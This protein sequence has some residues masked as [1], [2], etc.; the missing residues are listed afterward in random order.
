MDKDIKDTH[1]TVVILGDGRSFDY[2]EN[3]KILHIPKGIATTPYVWK[4]AKE[5][6]PLNY[7]FNNHILSLITAL[8]EPPHSEDNKE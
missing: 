1:N 8:L 7:H 2:V 5:A 3:C 6:T 4:N